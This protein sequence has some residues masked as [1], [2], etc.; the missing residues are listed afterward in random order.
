MVLGSWEIVPGM[1]CLAAPVKFDWLLM[2]GYHSSG[3]LDFARESF[4]PPCPLLRAWDQ[5]RDL[6]VEIWVPFV[7]CISHIPNLIL[8]FCWTS[9]LILCFWHCRRLEST[10]SGW[11]GFKGQQCPC[12]W[13]LVQMGAHRAGSSPAACACPALP[14]ECA[15]LDCW[16]AFPPVPASQ[17]CVCQ[18]TWS[19]LEIV[20]AELAGE[21][22]LSI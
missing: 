19:P 7:P 18:C 20:R 17:G 4:V 8:V 16:D 11:E 21:R 12:L 14:W 5:E 15:L 1:S 10:S 22:A 2:P 13:Y 3:R 9:S 6:Q